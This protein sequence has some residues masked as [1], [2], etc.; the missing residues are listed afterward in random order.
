MLSWILTQELKSKSQRL[1]G[2]I[3]KLFKIN[4]IA[5]GICYWLKQMLNPILY[6]YS[7]I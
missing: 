2:L 1:T 7:H 6:S 4:P 3:F 5:T